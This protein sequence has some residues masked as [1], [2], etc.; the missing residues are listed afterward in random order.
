MIGKLFRRRKALNP[1]PYQE[2]AGELTEDVW[3][4]LSDK[5]I[6][7]ILGDTEQKMI[8]LQQGIVDGEKYNG[9]AFCR[10]RRQP[11]HK[12]DCTAVK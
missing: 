4:M 7:E 12:V 9:G 5:T 6:W 2:G 11:G 1:G 3:K 8:I 10:I